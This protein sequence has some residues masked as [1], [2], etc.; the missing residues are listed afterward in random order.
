MTLEDGWALRSLISYELGAKPLLE[1][2]VV[3]CGDCGC[4]WCTV[5]FYGSVCGLTADE[6][7]YL[8]CEGSRLHALPPTIVLASQILH[9]LLET[10]SETGAER[11]L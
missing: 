3:L 9:Q 11:F 10:R 4:F 6:V 1:W 8:A 5:R 7:C 2:G